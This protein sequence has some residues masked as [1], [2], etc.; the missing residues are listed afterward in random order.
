M[1]YFQKVFDSFRFLNL[2]EYLLLT[3]DV[4]QLLHVIQMGIRIR[5]SQCK[6]HAGASLIIRKGEK[7]LFTEFCKG[8]GAAVHTGITLI[9][10][11]DCQTRKHHN[12]GAVF[13]HTGNHLLGIVAVY[14]TA[15]HKTAAAQAH[16]LL[17]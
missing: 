13:F 1:V 6:K 12:I 10:M 4:K 16:R 17:S 8:D 3:E 11:R 9:A 5:C 15:G 14:R 2:P 7:H